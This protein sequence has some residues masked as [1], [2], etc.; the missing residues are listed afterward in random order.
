LGVLAGGINQPVQIDFLFAS[1]LSFALSV[2]AFSLAPSRLFSTTSTLPNFFKYNNL[3]GKKK[4]QKREKKKWRLLQPAYFGR[5]RTSEAIR[6]AAS[7]GPTWQR[8][9]RERV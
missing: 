1:C 9:S 2:S 8:R 3:A 5:T 6:Q 4:L 7:V